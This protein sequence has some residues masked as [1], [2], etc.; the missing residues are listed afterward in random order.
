MSAAGS[1]PVSLADHQALARS[2]LDANAL[3]YFEG[4]A[5]DELTVAAN[6]T[7][8]DG[9]ALYPRVLRS[10][11]GGHTGTTLL[12]RALAH[13]ILLAPVAYQ[14]LA[15]PDG[16]IASACAAAAQGAGMVVSTQASISLETI[17]GAIADDADRGPLWFQ[18]YLQHDRGFNREL[19]ARAEAAGYEAL[20]LTVDAPCS[21]ARDRERRTGFALPPDISAVNLAGLPPRPPGGRT[22]LCAGLVNQAADW[23]DLT[24]LQR[25]SRLPIILKGVLH[26]ADARIALDAGASG[27]IV[28]NHGGRVL[29]TAVATARALPA[30]TD[31]VGDSLAVLVDGGIRRGTDILKAIAL[32]ADAVL[33]GRPV[34][35]GLANAGAAGV[36]H[37]IRLLR[38]ELEIAMA[39][40]GCA[41]IADISS[42]LL[43]P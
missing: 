41:R 21:G 32:G 17:A 19:V 4:G 5:A 36:A 7:A 25:E 2:R 10:L 28:S 8:W 24:W 29:D 3:A 37:I 34:I 30:I 22:G 38:D 33:I 12:G 13:P 31:A 11:A 27:L 14:R 1:G 43:A 35:H 16:E 6:R 18:L 26:P 23:D 20:V 9:M 42:D 15:H 40:C 39:L